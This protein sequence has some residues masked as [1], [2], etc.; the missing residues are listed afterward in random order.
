MRTCLLVIVLSVALFLMSAPGATAQRYSAWSTPTV[1]DEVNTSSA[2]EFASAISK[3]DLSFYFQRGDVTM[4]GEDIWVIHRE[5]KD[6]P[7]GTPEKLPDTVNSSYND[8]GAFVS[9]DGHWLYFASDRP[10]GRGG[11]DLMASYRQHTHDDSAWEPASNLDDLGSP[12]NTKGFDSGPALFEDEESGLTYMYFVSNPAG[13]QNNGVDIYASVRNPDGSFEP[14]VKVQELSDPSWNEGRP[15]LRRDGL[16]IFFQSN[17]PGSVGQSQDL[18]TSTRAAT[19][20]P[21]STP[22]PVDELNTAAGDVTPALSWDGLTLYFARRP[23]AATD[24]QIL[25]STREKVHGSHGN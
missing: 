23:S 19:H 10:G 2:L 8:R 25:F 24:A 15:Y 20:D 13:S 14:P 5:R 12:I 16:E 22:I 18:W 7:W 3:D 1:F 9:S 4:S 21:W 11:F 6:A 17:R